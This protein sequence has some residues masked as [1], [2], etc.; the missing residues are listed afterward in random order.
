[1]KFW[2]KY[3]G[4]LAV[5]GVIT[6]VLAVRHGNRSRYIMHKYMDDNGILA[7]F[8]MDHGVVIVK[9]EADL[10]E[11]QRLNVEEARRRYKKYYGLDG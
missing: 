4:A 1:M 11:Q 3:K 7:D 2:N 6:T 10:P 5:A 8:I 9:T